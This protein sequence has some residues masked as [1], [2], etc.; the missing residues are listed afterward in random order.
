ME[1]QF[2]D[3]QI[4][5]EKSLKFW[6]EMISYKLP[7]Q[8]ANISVVPISPG[9]AE[10][11]QLHATTSEQITATDGYILLVIYLLTNTYYY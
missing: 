11:R 8:S 10:L 3:Q 2:L 1:K 4:C 7:A 5:H 6:C 9:P